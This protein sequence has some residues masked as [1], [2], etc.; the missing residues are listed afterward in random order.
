MSVQARS[1]FFPDVI[2]GLLREDAAKEGLSVET[3]CDLFGALV[4]RRSIRLEQ[5]IER[6]LRDLPAAQLL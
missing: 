5:I 2:P 4:R 1:E 3:A 6:K